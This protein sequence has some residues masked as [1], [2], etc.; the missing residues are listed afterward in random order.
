MFYYQKLTI[1]DPN[2]LMFE[3][4]PNYFINM[5][6]KTLITTMGNQG[7]EGCYKDPF[8]KIKRQLERSSST[9]IQGYLAL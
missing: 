5:T 2:S 4:Q 8:V 7:L 6:L 1:I 3:K 9:S